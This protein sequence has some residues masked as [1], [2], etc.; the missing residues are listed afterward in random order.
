MKK[1]LN[2]FG[3]FVLVLCIGI[4]MLSCENT[5]DNNNGS[6]NN[7]N[8]DNNNN[9]NNNG[10]DDPF[11]ISAVDFVSNMRVGWNL[12][13]TFD[14]VGGGNTVAS[15]ESA[16]SGSVTTRAN[17]D[18]IKNAGFNVIR[19]PISWSKVAS[20]S[21]NY[22]IMPEWMARITQVVNWAVSNDMY[23]IINTHHDSGDQGTIFRFQDSNVEMSLKTFKQ[24]WEQ[25]ADNFKW[26]DEKLIFEPLNEPRTPGSDWNGN[27]EK[28][29]N[30]NR[31][32]QAFVDLVRVS[33]GNND[34]RFLLFNTYA[35]SRN[36]AAMNG[37]VLPT[38]TAKDK[39]IVSYHAYVPD[40]FCFS[41]TTANDQWSVN[42][43][44]G[45]DALDITE[46]MDRYYAK[47]VE[48]GIPVII[49]EFGAMN[50]NN[51]AIRGQWV[52]YY[53]KSARERGMCVVWWD[54]AKTAGSGELFGLLNRTT[55]QIIY[56]EVLNGLINGSK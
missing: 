3:I 22:A 28:Y 35:A 36:A 37:L 2:F 41:R 17:I 44:G 32:Y 47:F 39:L 56:P 26:F 27:A 14:A 45:R 21:D 19:I 49:G 42:G 33:G 52:D 4:G 6:E 29:N 54:N 51:A 40:T 31:H 8:G 7:N 15:M 13:N 43:N 16:W 9:N 20:I 11:N 18:A 38:D 46:P 23:I 25:I 1:I 12:G 30:L 48:K 55:N 5:N 34:K 50:K 24:I 10:D 53:A